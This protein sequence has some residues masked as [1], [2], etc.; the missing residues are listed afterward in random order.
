M[1]EWDRVQRE[2]ERREL[3]MIGLWTGGEEANRLAFEKLANRITKRD[4]ESYL[5]FVEKIT[6]LIAGMNVVDER[7]AAAIDA[8]LVPLAGKIA[9]IEVQ[10]S[11]PRVVRNVVLGRGWFLSRWPLAVAAAVSMSLGAMVGLIIPGLNDATAV[12][13]AGYL[14]SSAGRMCRL[15]ERQYNSIDCTLPATVRKAGRAG[16]MREGDL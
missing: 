3:N 9:K 4:Q 2:H 11:T 10:A 16:D 1:L 13:Q 7:C 6:E 15:I 14:I 12:G 5:P 8:R